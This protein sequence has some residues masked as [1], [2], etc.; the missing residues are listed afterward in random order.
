MHFR[1]LCKKSDE[2]LRAT[3]EV[4]LDKVA[5]VAEEEYPIDYVEIEEMEDYDDDCIVEPIEESTSDVEFEE[6]EVLR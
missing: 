1:E 3:H 5:D 4:L 6:A 2:E